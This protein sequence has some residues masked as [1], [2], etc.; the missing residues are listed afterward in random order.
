MLPVQQVAQLEAQPPEQRWL[1][2]S[3][4]SRA[5]IGLVAG[6]PKMGKS[7]L[8]L[9]MATSVASATPLLDQFPVDDPGRVL[10][11]LAEDP[12]AQVRLRI[13][14]LCR[15]RGLDIAALDLHVIT[16]PS[17]R[18]DRQEDQQ[19]LEATLAQLRPRLLVLD[20]LVRLHA[21]DENS[22]SE[23]SRLLGF[24][25]QL[26]RTHDVAVILVHHIAKRRY[27]QPGLCLRGSSDLHA[28]SDSAIYLAKHDAG[29]MLTVE[30]RSAPAPDPFAIRLVTAEDGGSAHLEL[31][32]RDNAE[33]QQTT[34]ADRVLEQLSTQEQDSAMT[35]NKL[36]QLLRVNNGRLGEALSLL[37]T[38]G[39]IER[40]RG[41]WKAVVPK[42]PPSSAT[43]RRHRTRKDQTA[44]PF[45]SA[46]VEH[47]PSAAS[48]TS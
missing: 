7:W 36:R 42:P 16:A 48:G 31:V 3:I 5:A 21:L 13:E 2:R 4:W 19:R 27:A 12:T 9:Q 14:A 15:Q 6:S 8:V 35:R 41:G 32:D 43:T 17:L 10:I 38:Q 26:Q 37:E 33:P 44:L 28:F 11:F 39:R 18:I 34:L 45:S 24:I 30:H 29:V 47:K 23:I 22:S 25:R 46:P 1:I 40:T 20:P